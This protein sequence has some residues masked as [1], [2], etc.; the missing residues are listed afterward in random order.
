VAV[1]SGGSSVEGKGPRAKEQGKRAEGRIKNCLLH[2]STNKYILNVLVGGKMQD[3]PVDIPDSLWLQYHFA[4]YANPRARVARLVRRGELLRLK[5]GVYVHAESA[6]DAFVKGK[7]ANRI[8]GPSYVSFVY[9]LRWYGLIP[10]HAVH[11][12]SATFNKGRKKRYDTPAG[13][14]FYQDVSASAYPYGITFV[15]EA[16]RRFLMASPEKALC[17]ELYRISGI[18]SIQRIRALLFEDLRLDPDGLNKLDRNALIHFSGL[19]HAVTLNTF[20]KFL[21]KGLHA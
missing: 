13:S 19:Y 3:L 10:E 6:R 14:F 17:D 2:I 16:P 12:T 4:N 8:Y 1:Y 7:A 9:A 5:R 18:R 15:G 20:A 11:I 21:E